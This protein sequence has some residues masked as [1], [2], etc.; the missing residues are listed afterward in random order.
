MFNRIP[1]SHFV[2]K[3][4]HRKRMRTEDSNPLN[5]LEDTFCP[6]LESNSANAT[7]MAG[8]DMLMLESEV[9]DSWRHLLHMSLLLD[10]E[11]VSLMGIRLLDFW[12]FTIS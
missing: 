8:G 3:R 9:L 2:E 4:A 11:T 6:F 12:F 7:G 1:E 5:V 10:A